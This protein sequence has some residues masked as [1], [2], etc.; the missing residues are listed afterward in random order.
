M[1]E[2]QD[3]KPESGMR[4]AIVASRFNQF[5]VDVYFCGSGITEMQNTGH[6]QLRFF[7]VVL[8]DIFFDILI[9]IYRSNFSSALILNYC[10]C[11]ANVLD[12]CTY[13]KQFV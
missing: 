2:L 11:F 12:D 10:N 1:F 3:V 9:Y 5:I 7:S 4:I 8:C 6:S 13:Y